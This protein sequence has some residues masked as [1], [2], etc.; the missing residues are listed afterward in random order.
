MSPAPRPAARV[1]TAITRRTALAAGLAVP[2]AAMAAHSPTAQAAP[3]TSE[4]VKVLAFNIHAGIGIDGELD[5]ERVARVIE[6]SEADIIGLQEVDRHWGSR[7][8]YLDVAAE[9]A[10]RLEMNHVFG[11]NLDLAPTGD[12]T[13]RRQYGTAIL[14]R[15]AIIHPRNHLLTNIE[16][17]TRPT[18]QR[19][20]L[21]A[22]V[23]VRGTRINFGTTHLDHQRAEQRDLQ[24]TEILEIQGRS[25]LPTLLTGDLNA[26]PDAA[27]IVKLIE[28]GSYVDAF[29]GQ[30]A[31][32][33]PTE[34][35]TKR[36][37]YVLARGVDSLVGDEVIT[38][39]ASDHLPVLTT[40]T[41]PTRHA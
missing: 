26:E 14:S 35:P 38:T 24:V 7:S 15:H 13:E 16:Y 40:V 28:G 25:T 17:P 10:E 12:R 32:T 8:D 23:I 29:A 2:L 21:E 1:R 20:L 22:T 9:L 4:T 36:I 41:V 3:R 11:A 37:D 18:E 27:E 30:D 6:D 34:A 19:G 31:P 33:F 5:L 39:D